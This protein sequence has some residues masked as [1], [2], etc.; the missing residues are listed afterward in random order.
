MKSYLLIFSAVL[1]F[2]C[3]V[4]TPVK[5][6]EDANP[7]KEMGKAFV[8]E[9]LQHYQEALR[10][11]KSKMLWCEQSTPVINEDQAAG[12]MAAVVG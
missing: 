3:A 4:Y 12:E 11:M 8:S 5:K 7:T 1:L 2:G 6:T 9:A 10:L